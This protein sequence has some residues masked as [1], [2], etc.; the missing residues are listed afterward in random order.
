MGDEE[1]MGDRPSL[2]AGAERGRSKLR[3]ARV[4]FRTPMKSRGFQVRTCDYSHPLVQYVHRARLGF[5][6]AGIFLLLDKM[7]DALK[8]AKKNSAFSFGRFAV[9]SPKSF[10]GEHQNRLLFSFPQDIKNGCV[11]SVATEQNESSISVET[12]ENL[13]RYLNVKV[14]FSPQYRVITVGGNVFHV[15]RDDAK[16]R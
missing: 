11:I 15:L 13:F 9:L 7:P 16:A 10:F 6:S 5:V 12:E 2:E 4:Y 3:P 8:R 1:E 14:T